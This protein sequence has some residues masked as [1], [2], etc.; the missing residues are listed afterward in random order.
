MCSGLSA[1][2]TS[3]SQAMDEENFANVAR[4]RNAVTKIFPAGED[5]QNSDTSVTRFGE[6]GPTDVTHSMRYSQFR[7]GEYKMISGM[8]SCVVIVNPKSLSRFVSQNKS[9]SRVSPQ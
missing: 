8:I 9:L 2:Q 6:K 5:L 4:S 7:V 3:V 1:I